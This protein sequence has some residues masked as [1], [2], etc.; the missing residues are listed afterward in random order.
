MR[1]TNLLVIMLLIMLIVLLSCDKKV[2]EGMI[3]VKG[4]TFQ[5]GSNDGD[6]D[7]TPV[8][9][10]KVDDYFIGEYEVTQEEWTEVMG[11]NPSNWEGDN[12]PVE[13]IMWFDA[14]KFC[15]E[16]SRVEGLTPC[17]SGSGENTICDFSANGY[18]LP[19]EAEWEY[20]AK[21]GTESE[22]YKYSGSDSIDEVAWYDGNSGD[23]THS[24]GGKQPNELGIYDMS[25]NVW[26]WCND[27]YDGSND[28]SYYSKSSS[29][30]PRGVSSGSYRVDRGGGWYDYAKYCRVANRRYS[31]DYSHSYLGFRLLRSS[32]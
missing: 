20:A 6:S 24:V 23:K 21:G 28:D 4:G 14:V 32:K 5:M 25:G 12:L 22:N 11:D 10:V 16:K 15:N 29:N 17:Y 13:Q 31:P 30:N 2:H 3:F 26:E 7:E 8:H 1:S 19:T 9:T 18:R 27:W